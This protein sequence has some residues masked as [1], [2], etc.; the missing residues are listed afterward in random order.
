MRTHGKQTRRPRLVAHVLVRAPCRAVVALLHMLHGARSQGQV[1]H[2][3]QP[4]QR[5][6]VL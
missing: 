4:P 2:S 1:H 3:R 6:R 5:L